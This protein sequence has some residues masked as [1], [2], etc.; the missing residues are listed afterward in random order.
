M[1]SK[2][3]NPFLS[4]G[5]FSAA[6]ACAA[7][8]IG[9]GVVEPRIASAT[10]YSTNNCTSSDINAL[11]NH[12]AT[13]Q[14][15]WLSAEGSAGNASYFQ[16]DV[17]DVN[18]STL[19]FTAGTNFANVTGFALTVNNFNETWEGNGPLNFY[20]TKNTGNITS[21]QAYVAGAAYGGIGSNFGTLGSGLYSLGSQAFT[22][23][24]VTQT[25]TYSF[26]SLDNTNSTPFSGALSTYLTSQ[27]DNYGDVRVLITPGAPTVASGFDG[28]AYESSNTGPVAAIDGTLGTIAQTDATLAVSGAN[29]SAGDGSAGNPYIVNLGRVVAGSNASKPITLS[30]SSPDSQ[31]AQYFVAGGSYNSDAANFTANA[32][33][34][35]SG[36]FLGGTNASSIQ[37]NAGMN[38]PAPEIGAV[39]AATPTIAT[40]T[41]N[42]SSNPSNTNPAGGSPNPISV[43]VEAN[44]VVANRIVD[45]VGSTGA[46]T[47]VAG[48]TSHAPY[49]NFGDVLIPNSGTNT[50]NT[51]LSLTTDNNLRSTTP[52]SAYNYRN[53]TTLQLPGSETLTNK[54]FTSAPSGDTGNASF[55]VVGG[56]TTQ[57]GGLPSGGNGQG[58]GD[59]G[60]EVA[61]I[62]M[63]YNL[64]AGD[65]GGSY[66]TAAAGNYYYIGYIDMPLTQLDTALGASTS[67]YTAIEVVANVYQSASIS[68]SSLSLVNAPHTV[69]TVE[70][71]DIGLRDSAIVTAPGSINNAATQSTSAWSIDPGFTTNATIGDGASLTA[72]DFNSTNLLNGNYQGELTGVGLENNP[73]GLSYGTNPGTGAVSGATPNDLGANNTYIF[74]SSVSTNLGYAATANT[75]GLLAGQSYN[76]YSIQRAAGDGASSRNTM[77]SFLGGTVSAPTT[78]SVQ[79]SNAPADATH[80]ISD[81]ATVGGTNADTY[82]LELS[83]TNALLGG[84]QPTSP[85]LAVDSGGI[86]KAAV[87]LNSG[88][89]AHEVLGAYN[90][91]ADFSLGYYGV[92]T[93]ND[94]VWA[95]LNYSG[96]DKFGVESRLV[97]DAAGTG[98]I[99]PQ[100]ISTVLANQG[101]VTNLFSLGDF[102]GTDSV[103]PQDISQV[104]A[105]QG[106]S[107]TGAGA[108]GPGSIQ[109]RPVT[110]EPGSLGILALGGIGLL[111]KRRKAKRA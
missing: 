98:Q 12:S 33:P 11:D 87:L 5:L 103:T 34:T 10:S 104:L 4:N 14:A 97:G 39:T 18:A 82:V 32:I 108:G 51:T 107:A 29:I 42:N 35:S 52:L 61:A 27:V 63:A 68:T 78:V 94:V 74:S 90:S 28:S 37:I 54:T 6:A 96:G 89:T 95:V 56:T 26:G 64:P 50:F 81:Y 105:A 13:Y 20:V 16:Y 31:Q 72:L 55:S 7:A 70:G 3:R 53:L 80:L 49:I 23:A 101:D 59:A 47:I 9:V 62:N 19:P 44:N 21:S 66:I 86:L 48:N 106:Q 58:V 93:I 83:Y 40:L 17:V 88:G 75:A 60:T 38:A 30:A 25:T 57:F 69:N 2:R 41:V 65:I 22:L 84:F 110:P 99:T 77:V 73:V 71:N 24:N 43:N 76:G 91:G 36:G 100:D 1:V 46:A 79:F 111:L 8:A 85:V 45:V 109:S 67:P 102:N 15:D 92:D